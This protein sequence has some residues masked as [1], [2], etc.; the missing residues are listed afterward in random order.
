MTQ[1]ALPVGAYLVGSIS[2][3]YVV[4]WLLRGRDIREVGS[5]NA[6]A[7]NVLR[8]AGPGPAAAVLALDVAKGAVPVALAAELGAG[9]LLTGATALAAVLGHVFPIY[10]RFRGGKG[11]ATALGALLALAF[12]PAVACV[13]VILGVIAW[14]RF[15]SL[16]SIVGVA[17]APVLML[18]WEPEPWPVG[19]AAAIALMV[20]VRHSSNIGRLRA[21]TERRLGERVEIA[22]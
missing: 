21:G 8:S 11:V 18:F 6:G 9:P 15:V 19:T 10:I 20:I 16:G 4:F 12:W 5:G 14:T 7:T 13:A 22:R 17:L 3:S 1:L 2:F